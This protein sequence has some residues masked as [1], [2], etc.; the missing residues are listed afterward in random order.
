MLNIKKSFFF[1]CRNY[2]SKRG[3]QNY[4]YDTSIVCAV[5]GGNQVSIV[6]AP[7]LLRRSG[8]RV[9]ADTARTR[10]SPRW[11]R[12]M[13]VNISGSSTAG[14][15]GSLCTKKLVQMC[16]M[17]G[18]TYLLAKMVRWDGVPAA[19]VRIVVRATSDTVLRRRTDVARTA[20]ASG[21]LFVS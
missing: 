2:F 21:L 17:V 1:Q 6:T 10:G 14:R 20:T 13:C 5:N 18:S 9:D 12:C 11:C 4:T 8:G 15:E 3:G 16:G 19:G 7:A